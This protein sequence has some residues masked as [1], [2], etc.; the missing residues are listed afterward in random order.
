[1]PSTALCS[2]GA[3]YALK[4]EYAGLLV[5]C[6][7]CGQTIKASGGNAA[8]LPQRSK[9]FEHDQFLLR[10]KHLSLSE[11]YYVW[12]ERGQVLLFVERPAHL[13]RNAAALFAG[14]ISG[15]A[16]GISLGWICSMVLK[17]EAAYISLG[18]VAAIITMLGVAIAL[19][20]K[21]HVNFYA[22]DSKQKLLLRVYQDKKI[23]IIHAT[24]TIADADGTVLA[25]FD[26]N[27]LYNLFRKQWV[28][29]STDG[30]VICLA[31][32]DSIILSL[33]RRL[34][35]PFFGLLRTNFIIVAPDD[36]RIL[37][38]FNRKFTILDRYSLNL[39]ADPG[40]TLDRRIALALG[41][42]LDT[43]E[44]R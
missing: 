40:R 35:G 6:R 28:C 8:P 31:K 34:I 3:S 16:M 11:K 13:L 14:I 42:M 43:G 22:D 4:D 36:E 1:M 18:V 33:L 24:Y 7:K 44:R 19:S 38:E 10:Q 9:T 27:Y 32:E 23:A 20:A 41:V 29:R 12:D 25:T 26:K 5:Q 30:R 15:V 17:D 37:G 2:C 21:R 39:S